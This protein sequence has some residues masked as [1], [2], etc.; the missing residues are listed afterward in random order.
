M[1]SLPKGMGEGFN[2]E[3]LLDT[4]KAKEVRRKVDRCKHCINDME[5]CPTYSMQQFKVAMWLL[6][7]K[8]LS[9][10][11]KQMFKK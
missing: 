4:K 7:R 11:F 2:L 3:K 1:Y 8:P 10:F 6:K 9:W 5:F